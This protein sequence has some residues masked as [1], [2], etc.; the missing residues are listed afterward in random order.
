MKER[1]V[2]AFIS[3]PDIKSLLH[4][5]DY[6]TGNQHISMCV[7]MCVSVSVFVRLCLCACT[8]T[9][10]CACNDVLVDQSLIKKMGSDSYTHNLLPSIFYV[11]G[12]IYL[13]YQ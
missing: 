3:Q 9:W 10:I 8:H 1:C 11:V 12:V 5:L 2:A 7:C 4:C 6:L 13:L